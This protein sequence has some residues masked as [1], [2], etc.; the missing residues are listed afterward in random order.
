MDQKYFFIME[1][2]YFE[3]KNPKKIS[4]IFF[5]RKMFT[6]KY[7][8]LDFISILHMNKVRDGV[9]LR[10]KTRSHF[11]SKSPVSQI[12][13]F[14]SARCCIETKAFLCRRTQKCDSTITE[15]FLSKLTMQCHVNW[16]RTTLVKSHSLAGWGGKGSAGLNTESN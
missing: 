4:N 5:F 16:N 1:K 2:N 12:S 10:K 6:K 7:G 15:D 9:S 14:R 8:L 3:K 13:S 11:F